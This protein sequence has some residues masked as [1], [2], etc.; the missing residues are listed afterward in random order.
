MCFR[1][2]RFESNVNSYSIK[3]FYLNQETETQNYL[4][5]HRTKIRKEVLISFLNITYLT[6]TLW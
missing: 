5:S 4:H 6:V 3:I 1:I 2:T